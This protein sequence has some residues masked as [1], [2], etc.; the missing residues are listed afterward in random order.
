[1]K[2]MVHYVTH[3]S[4]LYEDPQEK[5]LVGLSVQNSC[6]SPKLLIFLMSENL[7]HLTTSFLSCDG[8]LVAQGLM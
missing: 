3:Y 6:D 1:M 8:C 7:N 5:F 4:P 2:D